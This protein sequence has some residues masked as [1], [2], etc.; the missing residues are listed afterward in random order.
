MLRCK[1]DELAVISRTTRSTEGFH[2][3]LVQTLR[4][5]RV[6]DFGLWTTESIYGPWWVVS[7]C[8]GRRPVYT[9]HD[10]IMPPGLGIWPDA[11]LRPIRDDGSQF[12]ESM[13]WKCGMPKPSLVA[14]SD[15][16]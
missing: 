6:G 7:F 3:L 5:A 2:G 16:G 14:W 12:D 1:A 15:R 13:L 9:Q 4:L 10:E 11:W 8:A